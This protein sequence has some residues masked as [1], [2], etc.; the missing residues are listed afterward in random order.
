MS[1]VIY[2]AGNAVIWVYV[3]NRLLD[4]NDYCIE[5]DSLSTELKYSGLILRVNDKP[6]EIIEANIDPN[7]GN[8][9]IHLIVDLDSERQIFGGLLYG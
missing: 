5:K 9:I 3:N 7:W 4:T 8:I 2:K 6:Y 1:Q